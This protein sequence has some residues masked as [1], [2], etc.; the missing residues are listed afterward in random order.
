MAEISS[1]RRKIIF[2]V[3]YR[4]PSQNR[5]DF[6]LF[7][8]KLQL[9]LSY[10][11]DIKPYSIVLTGDFNCRPS[12]WWAEDTELPERTALDELI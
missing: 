3:T 7:L 5:E 10:I 12:Q 9:T 1:K 4:S 8:D 6:Y 11:N 2:V